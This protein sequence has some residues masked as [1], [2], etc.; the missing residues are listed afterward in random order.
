[1][2]EPGNGVLYLRLRGCRHSNTGGPRSSPGGGGCTSHSHRGGRRSPSL[3]HSGRCSGQGE[4]E[5]GAPCKPCATSTGPQHASHTRGTGGCLQGTANEHM[6]T[7]VV[8]PSSTQD[9]VAIP[10]DW[11]GHSQIYPNCS[12]DRLAFPISCAESSLGHESPGPFS[13]TGIR[14]PWQGVWAAA[15]INTRGMRPLEWR[16]LLL[17][18]SPLGPPRPCLPSR[19]YVLH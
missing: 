3:P 17:H 4:R 11:P 7:T 6:S 1:M 5:G 14:P 19:V 2:L 15:T 18:A 8:G 12:L 10:Y 16:R 13:I 9:C